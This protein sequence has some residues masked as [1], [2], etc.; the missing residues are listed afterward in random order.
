MCI[1]PPIAAIRPMSIFSTARTE[2]AATPIRTASDCSSR[3]TRVAHC[4]TFQSLN[5]RCRMSSSVWPAGRQAALEI[6]GVEQ[7][8]PD[9]GL[10]G[11]LHQRVTH[12]V[13]IVVR[14]A[15]GAVVQVVELADTRHAGQGHLGVRR[16]GQR[17]IGVR[18]QL[19]RN[20][21]HA[22]APGPEGPAVG[23]GA[24]AQG[25]VE[26][27][28]VGVGEARQ[29]QPGEPGVAVLGAGPGLDRGDPA[30]VTDDHPHRGDRRR[31]RPR[32]CSHQ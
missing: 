7:R 18:I 32:R 24:P 6:A 28:R 14:R 3:E 11:R 17:Q 13:R 20:G 10:P 30:V 4:S 1:G 12:R 8:E 26:R 29:H 19:R 27:V 23:V 25:A 21:V 9:P 31:C 2:C 5:R 16:P 22:L 15:V